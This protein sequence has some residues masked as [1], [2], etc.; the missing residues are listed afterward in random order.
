MG[1]LILLLKIAKY[2]KN[3]C[4]FLHTCYYC[5]IRGSFMS[6]ISNK[7]KLKQGRGTG[8][9][10]EYK[11]FIKTR[12]FNSMGTCS[13]IV[14]WK[15]GRQMQ[16][17]SQT[18]MYVFMQLRW[19]DSV[20]EIRE[21][22]PLDLDRLSI[23]ISKTNAELT[24]HGKP[25]LVVKY[26]KQHWLTT[27]MV[28]YKKGTVAEAISVKYDKTSLSS[29]DVETIWVEKKYWAEQ[30]VPLKLMD[31]TDVNQILVKKL[32]IVMEYYDPDKVFDE[33]SYIKHMIATKQLD[34]SIENELLD[35]RKIK[36]LIGE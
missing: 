19:D 21:Q 29:K 4:I 18:E 31:R 2:Q 20:D 36:N 6:K 9:G 26:D 30:N 17:L 22:F 12:E 5:G 7:T 32:R 24:E 8:E 14:D 10:K 23:I 13:N 16:F 27:D 35:L 1:A 3:I 11:P 28:V 15:T 34:V 25:A 33:D